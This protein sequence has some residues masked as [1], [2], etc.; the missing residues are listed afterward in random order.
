VLTDD[1]IEAALSTVRPIRRQDVPVEGQWK[2]PPF[3]DRVIQG[4]PAAVICDDPGLSAMVVDREDGR[5]LHLDPDD[6]PWFAN[7]SVAHFVDCLRAFQRA[8][9]LADRA[10]AGGS[11]E[12]LAEIEKRLRAELAAIDPPSIEDENGFWSACAE[13]FGYGM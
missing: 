1:T 9:R 7:S 12:A 2:P 10:E 4:H 6:R 13:E 8:G 3:P 5:V 11:D